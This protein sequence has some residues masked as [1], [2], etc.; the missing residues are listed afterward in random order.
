[1]LDELHTY[2]GRQGADVALLVRRVRERL[3]PERLQCVGTS[4]TMASEGSVGN[5]SRVVARVASKLFSIEIPESNVIVETLDRVTDSTQDKRLRPV[6]GAAIDA[7][8]RG[9][10]TDAELPG[11]V[12]LLKQSARATMLFSRARNRRH[13]QQNDPR[14]SKDLVEQRVAVCN[15]ASPQTPTHGADERIFVT[16]RPLGGR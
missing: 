1:M 14:G 9:S 6:L 4:A 2:R 15:E 13:T 5:K 16:R 11:V 3:A 7:G 10:V 8:L 12:Y